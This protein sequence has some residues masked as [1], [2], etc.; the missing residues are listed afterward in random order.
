MS[1]P[2]KQLRACVSLTKQ[3]QVCV[4]LKNGVER[5]PWKTVTRTC[6]PIKIRQIGMQLDRNRTHDIKHKLTLPNFDNLI[7]YSMLPKIFPGGKE[8][9]IALVAGVILLVKTFPKVLQ[10]SD[11]GFI[12]TTVFR[13]YGIYI[14]E[15]LLLR[16]QSFLQ[17]LRCKTWSLWCCSMGMLSLGGK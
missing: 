14:M 3:L 9:A 15:S 17:F 4:A 7:V 6:G 5:G 16:R 13:V 10:I 11:M 12:T 1:C 2:N 8:I